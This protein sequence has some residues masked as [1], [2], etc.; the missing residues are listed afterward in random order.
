MPSRHGRRED[1]SEHKGEWLSEPG[2]GTKTWSG[3]GRRMFF[4][5]LMFL[6]FAALVIV[7]I[8]VLVTTLISGLSN[9]PIVLAVPLVLFI[10][11]LLAGRR[12][13]RTWRPVRSLIGA[14]GSLADG[15]YS[16]RVAP[17][18]SAQMRSVVAS[19]NDMAHR[20]ETSD[21][22]RRRLLADLGHELRTPLTVIRGEVEAM[23][24]G[25]HTMD[26]E[27]LEMLIAEVQIME[28]LLEDLRTLSLIEAGTLPL[29]PEPV[30]LGELLSDVSDSFL[31]RATETGVT[32]SV[33]TDAALGEIVLDPVR[34]RE[35]ISNVV[36][37]ALRAMPEGGMLRMKASQ[38]GRGAVI[39]VADTG[40][41]IAGDEL[42]MVFERFHKGST[43]SGSGLGLTISR[44]LVRAHG[45]MMS[46]DSELGAGTIVRID[47]SSATPDSS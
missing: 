28:R 25:V 31:R 3:F 13:F 24:D 5:F 16:A 4:G 12:F 43:S 38:V 29:H 9:L 32:I 41:G 46:V 22:L 2:R 7:G 21:E 40:V 23:I 36:V 10:F 26:E 33:E 37:N 19:F 35:V 14:A 8:V 27:H 17:S 34:I 39:E 47:L 6:I 44:D 11:V 18:G 45:G 1:W 42:D 30:D 15:D 20:L